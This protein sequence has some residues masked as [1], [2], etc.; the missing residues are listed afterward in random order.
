MGEGRVEVRDHTAEWKYCVVGA[1][2]Q[3]L[4]PVPWDWRL[5]VSSSHSSKQNAVCDTKRQ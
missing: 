5:K 4:R 3:F 2:P 1:M